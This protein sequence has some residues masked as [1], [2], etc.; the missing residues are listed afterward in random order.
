MASRCCVYCSSVLLDV[1]A[2][3]RCPGC[4]VPAG[5]WLVKD[6]DGLLVGAASL[7]EALLTAAFAGELRTNRG[8]LLVATS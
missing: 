3:A 1:G 4:G 5:C 7:S 8:G 2:Q 6:S